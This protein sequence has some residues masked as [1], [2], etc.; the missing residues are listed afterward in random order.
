MTA[1]KKKPLDEAYAA[2][3][4]HPN[5]FGFSLPRH[6]ALDFQRPGYDGKRP[7]EFV[8]PDAV[9]LLL[10]DIWSEPDLY[11]VFYFG[12]MAININ[13]RDDFSSLFEE[14]YS[15]YEALVKAVEE[16]TFHLFVSG[17]QVQLSY[18]SHG[19]DLKINAKWVQVQQNSNLLKTEIIISRNAVVQ[20]LYQLLKYVERLIFSYGFK[21]SYLSDGMILHEND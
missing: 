20:E 8:N 12:G 9:S 3:R 4:F 5:N 1:T 14:V 7:L 6:S 16:D 15:L 21:I 17:F 19:S 18:I 13:L 2:M 10:S 11:L